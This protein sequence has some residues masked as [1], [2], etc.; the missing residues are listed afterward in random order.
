VRPAL[1]TEVERV[2]LRALAITEPEREEARRVAIEAVKAQAELFEGLGSYPAID[3][4]VRRGARDPMEMIEDKA[5]M[6]L[7]AEALM[8]ETE[9]PSAETVKGAIASLRKRRID[10]QLRNLRAEIAEAERRGDH[11]GLALLTQQKMELDRAS[12]SLHG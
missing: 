7:L 1:L 12:R 4:L 5:Q 2:L 11:A 9:S 8:G 10:N 6:A 3:A